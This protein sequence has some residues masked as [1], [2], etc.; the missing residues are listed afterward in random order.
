MV[1]NRYEIEGYRFGVRSTSHAFASWLDEAMA[2]YRSPAR[3]DDDPLDAV[4]SIVVEDGSR[5]Q[6]RPG[7]A[8]RVGK[9]FHIV[10]LGGW[11]IVRTLD[12]THLAEATLWEM[13]SVL[14]PVRDDVAFVEA[15]L[16]GLGDRTCLVASSLIPGL[17]RSKRR[18][19]RTG[20]RSPGGVSFA[21]D[22]RT[23]ELIDPERRLDVPPDALDHLADHLPVPPRTEHR[24]ITEPRRLDG[25][26]VGGYEA[27]VLEPESRATM[28]QQLLPTVR[29]LSAVGGAGVS[30]VGQMLM[31]ARAVR[32]GYAGTNQLY[33]VLGAF[34]EQLRTTA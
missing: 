13:E 31:S 23:G 24:L 7:A 22:L 27:G 6:G 12:L 16:I 25:V 14:F 4:Y 21:V 8:E 1:T 17:N 26:F 20:V 3:P 15:G 32:G 19:E 2:A 10:Y 18:G 9:R 28:L 11:D 33:E 5:G 30:A 29:N 34:G